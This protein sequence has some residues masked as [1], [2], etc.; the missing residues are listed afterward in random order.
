MKLLFCFE[1]FSFLQ[2][3]QKSRERVPFWVISRKWKKTQEDLK[4]EG[5][6]TK[7]GQD[8]CFRVLSFYCCF[9]EKKQLNLFCF[10]HYSIN[11]VL[12]CQAS[13]GWSESVCESKQQSEKH[14]E[15]TGRG[16]R[17]ERK[18]V[19]SVGP[20]VSLTGSHSEENGSQTQRNV[21]G[22][23]A[24]GRDEYLN[25]IM[26]I[27]LKD[28]VLH[29]CEHFL[30]CKDRRSRRLKLD[31]TFYSRFGSLTHA[32]LRAGSLFI[33]GCSDITNKPSEVKLR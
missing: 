8:S 6:S 9:R 12:I 29:D 4:S 21:T 32:P 28:G 22:N 3:L 1:C 11:Q 18:P 23:E 16:A 2:V 24:N 26:Y 27:R 33:H 20:M 13:R 15:W 25:V 10:F 14:M 31:A 7:K 17:R 30:T 19:L 5:T